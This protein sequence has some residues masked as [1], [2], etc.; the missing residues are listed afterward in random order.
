VS[1]HNEF[2]GQPNDSAD[3]T[4]APDALGTVPDDSPELDN[5]EVDSPEVDE[6]LED[7]G[8]FTL[9]SHELDEDELAP[10]EPERV[11]LREQ[12]PSDSDEPKRAR[13]H[14]DDDDDSNDDG[15]THNP[16][17]ERLQKVLA[18]AGIASRRASELLI[19]EGRVDV[20]GEVVSTLGA[21]V[22]PDQDLVRVDGERVITSTKSTYM[23]L[24]KPRGVVSTMD[25]D[26]GRESIGN[27]LAGRTDRLF[28]VGRLD[29][30]TDG[31]ILLTNDGELANK[32]AH[33]SYGVSKT[34][35]AQVKTPVARD[36]GRRLKDGFDLEDGPVQAESFRVLQQ[37]IGKALVEIVVHEGRKHVV[38]RMLEA[39]GNPVETLTRT[40]FGPLHLGDLRA[41]KMRP[42]DNR[43]IAALLDA[44]S[45]DPKPRT[46]PRG[47]RKAVTP[48]TPLR[49]PTAGKAERK[50]AARRGE[51]RRE[52][53]RLGDTRGAASRGSSTPRGSFPRGDGA[54][55]DTR[56][57]S[58]GAAPRRGGSGSVPPRSTTPR[59][60]SAPR[61]G[62]SR[63][64]DDP[65]GYQPRS[66]PPRAGPERGW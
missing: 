43:E 47:P 6:G 40:A 53:P 13:R 20:N 34:Y 63:P 38:R 50:P 62:A 21:R 12:N 48:R 49:K 60:G 11:R 7:G 2:D 66:A 58:R 56:G 14:S 54:R 28:H 17:G 3:T 65:G 36:A 57:D 25:D 10:A 59:S 22:D 24:N 41:G 55:D 16:D 42:L 18:R 39:V 26:Q 32:L 30:D 61:F 29:T 64:S 37:N 15:D 52:D 46:S 4:A 1:T 23:M 5:R 51:P 44:A 8:A 31:L 33:P 27:L 19:T 9:D 35:I 45:G